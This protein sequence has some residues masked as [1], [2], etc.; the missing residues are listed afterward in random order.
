MRQDGRFKAEARHYTTRYFVNDV[1]KKGIFVN[2]SATDCQHFVNTFTN[3]FPKKFKI[4]LKLRNSYF[5]FFLVSD[6][7][8][9]T[10]S[11]MFDF[12]T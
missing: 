11:S 8:R 3:Q 10:K 5:F 1:N 9:L 4:S 2:A 6:L 12:F 7:K